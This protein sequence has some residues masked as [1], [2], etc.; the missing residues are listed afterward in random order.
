M[1]RCIHR[2][3]EEDRFRSATD[4]VAEIN[5]TNDIQISARTVRRRLEYFQL[6]VRR[7]RISN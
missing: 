7:P 6:R 4:I 3:Y 2:L 5:A 1:D